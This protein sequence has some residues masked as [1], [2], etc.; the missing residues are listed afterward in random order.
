MRV[1]NSTKSH[2]LN[3]DN[4]TADAAVGIDYKDLYQHRAIVPES[5]RRL[6]HYEFSARFIGAGLSNI[7]S[8]M[9]RQQLQTDA[10]QSR[11][12]F[13]LA[14]EI[15]S[16]EGPTAL[17]SGVR[18][19]MLR[20]GIY[21]TIRLGTY[22][23]HKDAGSRHRQPHRSSQRQA[24][25]TANYSLLTWFAWLVRMQARHIPPK[26]EYSTISSALG[27]VYAEGGGTLSGG[28]RSLWRGTAATVTR[29]AVITTAQIGSY[30]HFKQVV[31]GRGLMQEGV[32]LH[33]TSSLFAGLVCSI[34]SNP[35]DVIKVRLMNDRAREY[36]GILDCIVKT[37][38]NEGLLGYYKGFGMCWIR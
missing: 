12:F 27:S 17:M 37:I 25:E 11:H 13:R 4:D 23:A 7:F 31:K 21:A 2:L 3:E 20:E 24:L 10:P 36:N 34:V 9:V 18:A 1:N 8:S 6:P 26:P 5:V 30:D 16:I 33:L 15:I 32:P 14:K 38:R 19:S 28:L 29:G 22:E 35:V